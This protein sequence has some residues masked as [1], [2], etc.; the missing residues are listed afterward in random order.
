MNPTT[1]TPTEEPTDAPTTGTP[2]LNPTTGTP[3]KEPTQEPTN[4]NNPSATVQTSSNSLANIQEINLN[5]DHIA[6]DK[7]YE[8]GFSELGDIIAQGCTVLRKSQN[9][10]FAVF[11]NQSIMR[12]YCMESMVESVALSQDGF[13]VAI[14]ITPKDPKWKYVNRTLA[15][16]HF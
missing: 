4:E 5:R 15:V 7:H 9:G 12:E 3:T 2:T 11:G 13:A 1:G 14:A 10:T 8:F 6:Y 16:F